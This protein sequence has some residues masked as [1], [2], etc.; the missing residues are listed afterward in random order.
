MSDQSHA[1]WGERRRRREEE[2]LRALA[3]QEG[4]DD[5]RPGEGLG[6]STAGFGA[7]VEVVRGPAPE[8]PLSRRELRERAAA[9][10][11][12]PS[13]P[14][15]SVPAQAPT[16]PAAPRAT[17]PAAGP[18]ASDPSVREGRASSWRALRDTDGTDDARNAVGDAPPHPPTRDD[19]HSPLSPQ[20][21]AAA[22]RAQAA[23]A[24]AEREEEARLRVER[25]QAQR[26]ATH[27]VEAGPDA[28]QEEVRWAAP[29]RR[30]STE[31]DRPVPASR[32]G[33]PDGAGRE[34]APTVEPG[35]D[36]GAPQI[37]VVPARRVVL[38]PATAAGTAPSPEP[39][40]RPT[41]SSPVRPWTPAPGTRGAGTPQDVRPAP[42]AA[43]TAVPTA[44]PPVRPST[45]AAATPDPVASAD[46]S[47]PVPAPNWPSVR[48]A[49]RAWRPTP[50]GPEPAEVAPQRPDRQAAPEPPEPVDEPVTEAA[51]P[52]EEHRQRPYTWLHMIVL[53]LVA[54]VLG[55]LI[56]MV[57]M[58]D[59]KPDVGGAGTLDTVLVVGEAGA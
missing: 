41:T 29:F 54:F 21:R 45:P 51:E 1:E 53:V 33:T 12:A 27:R 8:R 48:P 42:T 37:P 59:T 34:K 18:T 44:A 30:P 9:A 50:P 7:Q 46:T 47:G 13:A 16:R 31:G 43:P 11:D 56:Y 15:P 24:Q 4:P 2:R 19:G 35:G 23:R 3:E 28:P 25:A 20:A 49:Q 17:G 40:V 14:T 52:V 32:F 39:V 38:P 22:I 36:T 57:V 6:A 58:K 26:A 5:N 10:A 55:M